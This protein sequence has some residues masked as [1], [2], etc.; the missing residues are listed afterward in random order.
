MQA[1]ESKYLSISLMP[2]YSATMGSDRSAGL[3]VPP[4]DT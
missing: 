1:G 2:H 4:E 3:E